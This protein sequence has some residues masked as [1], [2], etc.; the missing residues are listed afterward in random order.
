LFEVP[1]TLQL[2]LANEICF[3]DQ[4]IVKTFSQWALATLKLPM[5]AALD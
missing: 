1:A 5:E 2:Q 4:N 3:P